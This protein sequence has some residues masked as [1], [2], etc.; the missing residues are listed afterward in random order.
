MRRER[1]NI[2]CVVMSM[3]PAAKRRKLN[4]FSIN[5]SS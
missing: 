4:K 5:L 2:R 1:E 3:F